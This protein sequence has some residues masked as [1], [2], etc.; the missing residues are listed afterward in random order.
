MHVVWQLNGLLLRHQPEQHTETATGT[1]GTVIPTPI[2]LE[3]MLCTLVQLGSESLISFS[4]T[5]S[6]QG[7]R[8]L[9]HDARLTR[10]H[11]PD[12][13]LCGIAFFVR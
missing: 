1:A 5:K 8:P 9:E 10:H 6:R 13:S 12:L 4:P 11:L 3:M 7:A 2:H